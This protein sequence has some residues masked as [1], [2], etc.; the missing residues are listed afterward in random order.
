M[1]KKPPRPEAVAEALRR[2]REEAGLTLEEAAEK[3]AD[4]ESS[5]HY[6][7]M[8]KAFGAVVR[9]ERK[10]CKYSI[11]ELANVA[12]VDL[13]TLRTIETGMTT[14]VDARDFCQIAFAVGRTPDELMTM[15]HIREERTGVQ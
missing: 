1:L 11:E 13:G 7:R 9:A 5:G 15:T 6:W 12:R 2:L 3:L 8:A 10:R 14:D 4:I